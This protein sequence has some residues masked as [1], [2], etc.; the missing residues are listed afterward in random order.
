MTSIQNLLEDAG[1]D[2]LSQPVVDILVENLNG[3]TTA[4]AVGVGA[5]DLQS[6]EATLFVVVGD[7]TGSMLPF[8]TA[9][10]EAYREMLKALKASKAAASI[11]MSLWLFNEISHLFHAFLPLDAVPELTVRTY[12][13]GGSTAL[14]DAVLSACTSAVAYAQDLRNNGI[15][16]R[17]VFV[18]I[19]DGEDNMSHHSVTE[20][21]SVIRALIDQEMY[22]FALVGFGGTFR[23]IGL[24]MGIPDGN[25]LESSADASSIR[26]AM[27]TV[28]ASVIKASQAVIGS[29]TN[30]FFN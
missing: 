10:V 9:F 25:I 28:S 8:Q 15:R 12:L 30:T 2:G 19:T 29:S 6:D 26:H 27:G 3:V 24:G 7:Q 13:P 14:Y 21:D 1:G 16:V 17:V 22:T 23:P 4:G 5:A 18:I 20:V 11:I